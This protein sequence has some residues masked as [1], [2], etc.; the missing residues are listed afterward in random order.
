[1]APHRWTYSSRILHGNY[2]R[3]LYGTD[4]HLGAGDVG[5]AG[6]WPGWCAPNQP[7]TSPPRTTP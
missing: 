6:P 4:D 3:T 5:V 7:A 1:M 2:T